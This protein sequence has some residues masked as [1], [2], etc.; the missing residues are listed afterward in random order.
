MCLIRQAQR[1]SRMDP[2]K[3]LALDCVQM[4]RASGKVYG[5][6]ACDD[7]LLHCDAYRCRCLHGPTGSRHRNAVGSCRCAAG[8]A[9]CNRVSA[10]ASA[11]H[12][13]EGRKQNQSQERMPLAPAK[14][15]TEQE[16]SRQRSPTAQGEQAIQ[17]SV[18]SG[19]Q[20]GT[21]RCI[22]CEFSGHRTCSR[23]RRRL[24]DGAC[25]RVYRSIGTGRHRA[26]QSHG[27]G[28]P[29]AG[30]DGDRRCG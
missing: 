18:E 16:Q 9:R 24:G 28:E 27:A 20:R 2:T 30:C 22:H 8:T 25:G 11:R 3:N 7:G 26:C 1:R 5:R 19:A 4:E 12:S 17:R 14:R 29:A 6:G 13:D 23:N 21:S 10:S 15:H